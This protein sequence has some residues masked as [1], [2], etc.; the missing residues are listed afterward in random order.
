M[1]M[2]G[3]AGPIGEGR[4]LGKVSITY[5]G[6]GLAAILAGGGPLARSTG[7]RPGGV[8]SVDEEGNTMVE[9]DFGAN[10]GTVAHQGAPGPQGVWWDPGTT[11]ITARKSPRKRRR[12]MIRA[13]LVMPLLMGCATAPVLSPRITVE[14]VPSL[15]VIR[16]SNKS[17]RPI[18]LFYGYSKSFGALQ[19]FMVRF[20]DKSG[21]ILPVAGTPDGWFTPKQYVASLKPL[22]LMSFHVAA[23]RSI[24]FERDLAH[25]ASWVRWNG[26]PAEGPCEVQIKL[27]AY[28]DRNL[29]RS[30]EAATEWKPG[31]CPN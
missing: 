30:V 26:G 12:R 2:N 9:S 15:N 13:A 19:M 6:G 16:I 27:F 3:G 24:E 21:T 23:G 1:T 5:G 8:R 4:R 20:R 18:T 28:P 14:D 7:A 31:P 25:F 22:P 17:D 11:V 29:R 10:E